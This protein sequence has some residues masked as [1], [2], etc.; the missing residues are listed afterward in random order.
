MERGMIRVVERG[1]AENLSNPSVAPTAA[2]GRG[3][4]ADGT[5][6]RATGRSL[7]AIRPYR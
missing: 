5:V 4:E 3:R 7:S 2:R 1:G 6:V